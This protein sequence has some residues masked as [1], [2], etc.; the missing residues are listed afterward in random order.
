MSN[1]SYICLTNKEVS[2]TTNCFT[3][4]CLCYL[5]GYSALFSGWEGPWLNKT[6][7]TNFPR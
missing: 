7:E 1:T 4:A 6:P 2:Q 5:K 3:R